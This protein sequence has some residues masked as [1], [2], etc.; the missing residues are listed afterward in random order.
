MLLS[1]KSK[2][3]EKECNDL[4]LLTRAW[5]AEQAKLIARRLTELAVADNLATLRT[6]PQARAHELKGNREEQISLDVKH[7][8][9]LII[10][11]DYD[12]PPRRKDGGLEWQKITKIKILEV[13][14]THE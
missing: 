7:P 13:T 5:G 8:Y 11:H 1:F 6:L 10:I 3:F 4:K 9:R 2:K 12:E 14:D